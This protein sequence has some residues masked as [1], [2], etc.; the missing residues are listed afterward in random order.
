[1]S[2]QTITATNVDI[3][4]LAQQLE[5]ISEAADTINDLVGPSTMVDHLMGLE[6][7]LSALL[8]SAGGRST[9]TCPVCKST[10]VEGGFVAIDRNAATQQCYCN[11]CNAGWVD[12]YTHAKTEAAS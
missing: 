4:L 11:A 1:M 12:T 6:E 9:D 7:L 3:A 10:A 8:A 5:S 2:N